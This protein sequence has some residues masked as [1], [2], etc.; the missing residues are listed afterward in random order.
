M[1]EPVNGR[2]AFSPAEAAAALS[3]S[4][5]GLYNLLKSGE[6]PSI[7]IGASRRIRTEDLAGYLDRL[8]ASSNGHNQAT[9]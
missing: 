4:R 1:P 9:K 5:A 6:L 7:K 2:W 8:S 3:I